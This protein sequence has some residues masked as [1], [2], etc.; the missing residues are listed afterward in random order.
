MLTLTFSQPLNNNET[1]GPKRIRPI[2]VPEVLHPSLKNRNN[3]SSSD[4]KKNDDNSTSNKAEEESEE[5]KEAKDPQV[6][7]NYFIEHGGPTFLQVSS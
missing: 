1:E 7:R 6:N 5:D 4:S 2:F 3:I